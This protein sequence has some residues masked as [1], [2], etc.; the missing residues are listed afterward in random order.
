MTTPEKNTKLEKAAQLISTGKYDE[1]EAIALATLKKNPQHPHAHYIV[2]LAAYMRNQYPRAVKAFERAAKLAPKNPL[3]FCNLGESLRRNEEPE[4][5]FGAFKHGLSL[6]PNLPMAQLGIANC[7]SDLE[8]YD[9]AGQAFHK[10]LNAFPMFAPGYHY[11]GS[12][13]ARQDKHKQALPILR[14]AVAMKD[15]YTEAQ[16]T[17]AATLENL[18]KTDES[19]TLFETILADNPENIAILLNLANIKKTQGKNEEAEKYFARV[20]ELDPDNV[21]LQYSVSHSRDGKEVDDIEVMEKRLEDSSLN[22]NEQ[23]A[24]H[25]TIG[26]YYD[27][28]GASP[29]AFAHFKSGNDMDDRIAPYDPDSVSKG[30]D[31]MMAV[32]SEKFFKARY[33]MG[34]EGETPVFIVGMP[35]SG[36]SLIEQTLASHPQIFGAGELKNI[37]EIQRNLQ[38]RIKNKVPYPESIQ[39]LDPITACNM[40]ERYLKEISDLAGANGGFTR[41]TDKMPGN[42]ANL[43]LIA[44]IL[45]KARI[46][47][48]MRN[49]MDS[50]FSCFSRNFGSVISYTRQLE[51]LGRYYRD[52][53]RLMEHWKKVLPLE[54]LDVRYEETVADH[55]GMARKLIEFCGLEWDDACLKFYETERRV[56]TAST[57]QVRKPIYNS[58]VSKWHDYEA[59]LQPLFD[60]LGKYAP[61]VANDIETYI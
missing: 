43:G 52:Y 1:G 2:G 7:L 61:T 28:Q 53:R 20:K 18:D 27:D 17:L 36:T 22:K 15:N 57:V 33:G 60:A 21:A 3:V 41:I 24:L 49:P 4:K 45:P 11:M 26:K 55:D 32:F 12:H 42:I 30:M 58:S 56:K 29:Q 25:F 5:A 46:I 10:L 35:R 8:R 13:L 54:I 9:Q 14:K 34:A 50:C 6:Q 23:R 47:H 39:G 19:I 38:L 31:R 59:E 44:M 16:M 48:S 40:G 51:D 37:G